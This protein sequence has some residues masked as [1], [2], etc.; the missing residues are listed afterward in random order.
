MIV[1]Y[2]IIDH[3]H[4]WRYHKRKSNHE[5]QPDSSSIQSSGYS[6]VSSTAPGSQPTIT[7][8]YIHT[9][10]LL[11][12][13]TSHHINHLKSYLFSEVLSLIGLI[14]QVISSHA[15]SCHIMPSYH[16][17]IASENFP[18]MAKAQQ[19]RAEA[20]RAKPNKAN[21]STTRPEQTPDHKKHEW[22]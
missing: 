6:A 19:S 11:K 22:T 14:V 20:R 4:D 13:I 21:Q 1:E 15:I 9:S 17:Q 12:H 3:R 2:L 16:V 10:S 5:A 18:I 7:F 8:R